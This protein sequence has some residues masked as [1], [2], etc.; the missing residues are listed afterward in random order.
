MS[1]FIYIDLIC[2]L[3]DSRLVDPGLTTK[4]L[5]YKTLIQVS[6]YDS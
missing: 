2:S 3:L 4:F 6:A 1:Y 5:F